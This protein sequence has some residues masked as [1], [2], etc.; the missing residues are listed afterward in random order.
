M[1]SVPVRMQNKV[2]GEINLFY[3]HP[4]RLVPEELEL[5]DT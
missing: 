5:M 4:V 2:L 3:K 1:I